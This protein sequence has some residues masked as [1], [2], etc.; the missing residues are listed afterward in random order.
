MTPSCPQEATL[1]VPDPLM[2]GSVRE[3]VHPPPYEAV[4]IQECMKFPFADEV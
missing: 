4:I 1:E 3:P 2:C